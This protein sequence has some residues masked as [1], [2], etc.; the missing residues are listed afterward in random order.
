MYHSKTE[1]WSGKPVQPPVAY[2]GHITCKT[3]TIGEEVAWADLSRDIIFCDVLAETPRFRV[4]SL[5][6]PMKKLPDQRS[7]RDVAILNGC[8]HYFELQH[9]IKEDHNIVGWSAAK[10][11]MKVSSPLEAWHLDHKVD[12][13]NILGS[14]KIEGNARTAQPNLQSLCFG[15]PNLSLQEE[16]VVYCLA[17]IHYRDNEQTAWVIAID[18]SNNTIPEAVQFNAVKTVGISLGYGASRISKYLRPPPGTCHL[19]LT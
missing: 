3:I 8:I 12:S 7:V 2:P 6:P 9:Q 19:D 17:K 5:P 18:L 10:W 13:S 11:S 4:V 16:D 1:R 14:S 15:L